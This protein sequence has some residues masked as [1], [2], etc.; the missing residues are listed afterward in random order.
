MKQPL[1]VRKRNQLRRNISTT[2]LLEQKI[3]KLLMM[4]VEIVVKL[5][6]KIGVTHGKCIGKRRKVRK[7]SRKDRLGST[8]G[9]S[10]HNLRH[11][12]RYIL[13]KIV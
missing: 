12:R 8:I 9:V 7:M 4:M 5:R 10:H 3:L 1:V 13:F 6:L 2:K 11:A